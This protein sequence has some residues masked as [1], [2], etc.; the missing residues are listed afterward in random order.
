MWTLRGKCITRAGVFWREANN[1]VQELNPWGVSF[2]LMFMMNTDSYLFR[3]YREMV[4]G[5]WEMDGNV[6]VRGNE[7]YLPLYEAKLFHQYDHRFATFEGADDKALDGGNARE[8]TS[9]EKKEP[10]SVVIPRYW[11]PEKEVADHLGKSENNV[12]RSDAQTLR[13]LADLARRSLSGRSHE[14]PTSGRESSP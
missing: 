3:T 11:V 10:D 1:G 5:G 14:R 12:T 6:F 7:R 13:R 8:T 4:D 9:K 2:Q